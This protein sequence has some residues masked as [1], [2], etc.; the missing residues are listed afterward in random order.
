MSAQ[1]TWKALELIE[2]TA[3][4][5][6]RAGIPSARL[7]AELLLAHALNRNRMWLYLNFEHVVSG[8]LLDAFRELVRRRYARE[9]TAYLT[10][11][12]EFMSLRLR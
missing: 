6:E 11:R 1:K 7:D 9:P 12:R 10:G 4:Y 2:W 3:G 5:F 8:E